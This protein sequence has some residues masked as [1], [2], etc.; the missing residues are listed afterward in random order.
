[1]SREAL[2][3]SLSAVM[4]NEADELELRRVL[5]ASNDA[6]LRATWSRYQVA[7]AAMHKDLLVPKLDIAAAVSA[8][9]ENDATPVAQEKV[10]RGPWRSLGRVAVAATVTV[11]VL[12]GVRFYNQDD[13]SGAQLAQQDQPS[14]T[15]PQA[16]GPAILAGFKTSDEQPAV[17]TVSAE[18]EGWHEQRLP[19]Y[20]RQHGQQ[21]ASGAA[22]N[23]LPFARSASVEER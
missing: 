2:Q 17:E 12:A 18:G 9:L 10:V 5:G 7:R 20:L 13:V 8:A 4:D 6:E 23:A 3:E 11:A 1:M 21:S 16:Q 14:I 22:E 15:L 19:E